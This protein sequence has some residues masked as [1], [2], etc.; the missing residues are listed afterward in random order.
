MEG[1]RIRAARCTYLILRVERRLYTLR[2]M[3]LQRHQDVS[4][5]AIS[6]RPVRF[7][8]SRA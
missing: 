4:R 3:L 7:S 1:L 8:S 2:D 6:G 5:L